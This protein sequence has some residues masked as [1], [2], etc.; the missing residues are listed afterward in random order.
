MD[1]LI[2]FFK[3]IGGTS[4]N[5]AEVVAEATGRAIQ[6]FARLIRPEVRITIAIGNHHID[7]P[8]E[9][10]GHMTMEMPANTLGKALGPLV[11]LDASRLAR[12][13]REVMAA[14]VLEELFHAG[15]H[16]IDERFVKFIV[17]KA[18]PHICF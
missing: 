1:E 9:P 16:V 5:D 3:I 10:N 17:V 12:R 11:F 8:C 6:Y 2:P 14:I 18:M 4:S 7:V 15:C 13:N